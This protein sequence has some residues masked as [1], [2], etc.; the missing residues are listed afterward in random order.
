MRTSLTKAYR[1]LGKHLKEIAGFGGPSMD[2]FRLELAEL[3]LLG[4][5]FGPL[6]YARALEKHFCIRI[7]IEDFPDVRLENAR[8]EAMR[9]GTLAEV[10]YAEERGEALVLVRE[11]LR[12]R[13]WPAYDLALYHELS[14]VAARHPERIKDGDGLG[15]LANGG[16]FLAGAS[17]LVRPATAGGGKREDREELREKVYEPE[18]KRRARW[19]VLASTYPN[20]FEKDGA[21]RLS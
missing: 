11:S 5:A 17:K 3:N 18:A 2:D 21:N 4:R 1:L 20:F 16:R 8:R 13:P 9:E 10:F 14:H 6:D 12:M 15:R 7:E 19:L